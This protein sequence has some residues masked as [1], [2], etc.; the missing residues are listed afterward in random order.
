MIYG[1]DVLERLVNELEERNDA[2]RAI[3]KRTMPQGPSMQ[4]RQFTT[5]SGTTVTNNC[6][7]WRLT[8]VPPRNM[9]ECNPRTLVE[10]ARVVLGSFNAQCGAQVMRVESMGNFGRDSYEVEMGRYGFGTCTVNF[11]GC[12]AGTQQVDMSGSCF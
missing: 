5:F 12:N 9:R 6:R 10:G 7:G 8:L 11:S 3:K 4:R 1:N 2:A